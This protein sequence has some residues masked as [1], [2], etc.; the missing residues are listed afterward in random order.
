[1][2]CQRFKCKALEIFL[3]DNRVIEGFIVKDPRD[4]GKY[5]LISVITANRSDL[6]DVWKNLNTVNAV[7]IRQVRRRKPRLIKLMKRLNKVKD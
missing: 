6:Y 5:K 7:I 1:M 2:D 3:P 4:P